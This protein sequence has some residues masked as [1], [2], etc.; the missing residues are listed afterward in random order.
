MELVDQVLLKALSHDVGTSTEPN[1]PSLLLLQSLEQPPN[2]LMDKSDFRQIIH[3]SMGQHLS[4]IHISM[5]LAPV[6]CGVAKITT[7]SAL[8]TAQ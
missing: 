3:L 2:V 8:Q 5:G 1:I 4:L 6:R 7:P